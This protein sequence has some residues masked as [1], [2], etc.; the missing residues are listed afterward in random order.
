MSILENLIDGMHKAQTVEQMQGAINGQD[1]QM[2]FAAIRDERFY[3]QFPE[4]YL[5][6]AG[7]KFGLGS[8]GCNIADDVRYLAEKILRDAEAFG[9]SYSQEVRELA[10]KF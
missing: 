4:K 6:L 9:V 7:T 8:L 10:V 3:N 2:V 5:L 1:P